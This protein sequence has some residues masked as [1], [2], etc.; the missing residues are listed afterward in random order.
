MRELGAKTHFVRKV[1]PLA[2]VPRHCGADSLEHAT[3]AVPLDRRSWDPLRYA[4]HQV[5]LPGEVV[6]RQVFDLSG[7]CTQGA[8]EPLI[9]TDTDRKQ[10]LSYILQL[11]SIK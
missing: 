1:R 4:G 11:K 3:T 7:Y 2:A 6:V 8:Q 5:S 9:I 10:S